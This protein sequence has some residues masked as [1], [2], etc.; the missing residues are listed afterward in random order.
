GMLWFLQHYLWGLASEPDLG[1][2]QR[3]GW[4]GGYEPV[5]RAFAD[6]VVDELERNP[7][8]AVCFHDYHLYLAPRFVRERRPDVLLTHF[9]H[10][11]WA[12]SDYWHALPADLRCAIHEG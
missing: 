10:I 3:R 8:A 12:Q 9:V 1:A 5:N 6:A 4:T 2:E 11:P 7:D